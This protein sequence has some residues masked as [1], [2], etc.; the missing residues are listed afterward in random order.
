M[1]AILFSI[2][3]DPV[4]RMITQIPDDQW[5]CSVNTCGNY[6][7]FK[8]PT[9]IYGQNCQKSE[10]KYELNILLDL[11]FTPHIFVYIAVLSEKIQVSRILKSETVRK[12]ILRFFT[13]QINA[14]SLGVDSSVPLTHHDLKD[15]GLICLVKKCKQVRIQGR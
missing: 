2:L 5:S 12:R 6:R 4:H 11:I 15:L 8:S 9:N 14:R 7:Y 10:K 1:H 13:R 3:Y